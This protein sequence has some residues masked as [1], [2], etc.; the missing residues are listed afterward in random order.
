MRCVAALTV[1]SCAIIASG[2]NTEHDVRQ[3]KSTKGKYCGS[4][5][6]N[7]LSLV[8]DGVYNNKQKKSL[9]SKYYTPNE[10]LNRTIQV[11]MIVFHSKL[12]EFVN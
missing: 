3:M 6:S 8:C 9:F 5:L 11:N 4:Q 2:F 10:S 1:L 7:M 12:I